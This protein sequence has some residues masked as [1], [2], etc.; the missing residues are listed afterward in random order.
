MDPAPPSLLPEF[1][2]PARLHVLDFGVMRRHSRPGDFGTPGFL[3]TTGDGR[4]ILIDTGFPPGY[5]S[6]AAACSRLDGL[7]HDAQIVRMGPGNLLEGQLA[8]LGLTPSDISLTILTH[9]HLGQVGGLARLTHAPVLM[10]RAER[11]NP[12]PLYHRDA[13]PLAWPDADYR[14]IDD[15]TEIC[16]GGL[17]AIPTPGHTLG[18]LSV[19][20]ILPETGPVI[21][22]GDAIGRFEDVMNGFED[23]ADEELARTSA[24]RLLAL[25]A[26]SRGMVIYGHSPG[27]WQHIDKAPRFYG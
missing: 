3:L 27:Q 11:A 21:L 19:L 1:G 26:E 9:S 25:A 7:E 13:R 17:I 5:G 23:A 20:L 10:T 22:T 8:L 2:P 24:N 16:G 4:H 6:D 18:H 12:R 14:L 15:D